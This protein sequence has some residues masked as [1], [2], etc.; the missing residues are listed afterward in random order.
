M[1]YV[2]KKLVDAA[3]AIEEPKRFP[4]PPASWPY[5]LREFRALPIP[6]PAAV[7]RNRE[8]E[9]LSP[10]KSSNF[11]LLLSGPL[12]VAILGKKIDRRP[13]TWMVVW[14]EFWRFCGA[15]SC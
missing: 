5:P 15:L 6:A 11:C 3:V 12:L 14:K 9:T 13:R 8:G 10:A 2:P 7:L 4:Y 1:T